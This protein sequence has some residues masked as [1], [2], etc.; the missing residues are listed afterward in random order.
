MN[1]KI[2]QFEIYNYTDYFKDGKFYSTSV[3]HNLPEKVKKDGKFYL[4]LLNPGCWVEENE[5]DLIVNSHCPTLEGYDPDN[6]VWKIYDAI[7]VELLLEFLAESFL[8]ESP[9]FQ[10]LPSNYV[11]LEKPSLIK[12]FISCGYP[13]LYHDHFVQPTDPQIFPSYHYTLL[14]LMKSS[15]YYPYEL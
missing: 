7:E 15:R 11:H 10:K 13:S 3:D 8:K 9:H 5:R 4:W 14:Q 2:A 1:Q 12:G 6:R